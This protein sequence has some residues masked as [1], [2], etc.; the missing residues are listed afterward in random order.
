MELLDIRQ[1]DSTDFFYTI[2]VNINVAEGTASYNAGAGSGQSLSGWKAYFQVGTYKEEFNDI[3]DGVDII[4]GAE[5]TRNLQIGRHN[6]YLKFI[7]P[8]GK[9]GT[10]KTLFVL[11]V[12][13]EVVN[14][15]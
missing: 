7:T 2:H 10:T 6:A 13:N 15:Q 8:D 1:G 3:T 5:Q 9:I 14:V 11:N 12:T 4:I